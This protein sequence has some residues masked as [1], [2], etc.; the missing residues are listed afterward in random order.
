MEYYSVIKKNKLVPSAARR[1][2]LEII[3]IREV[4][5]KEKGKGGSLAEWS[6][7]PDLEREKQISYDITY[8]WN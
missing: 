4:S 1:M 5:Q 3:I 6:K 7:A 8:V 2:D